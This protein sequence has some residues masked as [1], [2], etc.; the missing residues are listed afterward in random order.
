[1]DV[2]MDEAHQRPLN[3]DVMLGILKKVV[4]RR[5]D[6]NLIVTSATLDAEKFSDFF[7][8]TVCRNSTSL[9]GHFL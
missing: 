4:A 8:G 7:G 6:F 9:A 5:R 2:I 1:M 3:T